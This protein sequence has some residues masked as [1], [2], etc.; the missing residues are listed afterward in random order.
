MSYSGLLFPFL[1]AIREC[2]VFERSLAEVHNLLERVEPNHLG[3]LVMAEL[4][5]DLRRPKTRAR[6]HAAI[7]L[8]HRKVMLGKQ[9]DEAFDDVMR[10][11]QSK[12][13]VS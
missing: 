5:R 7:R 10:Q 13:T 4:G 1:T 8:L 3:D 11:Y 12:K 6:A 2:A 9:G